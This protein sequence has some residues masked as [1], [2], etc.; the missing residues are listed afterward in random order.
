[1]C[2]TSSALGTR[3]P[4]LLGAT[5]ERIRKMSMASRSRRGNM[6]AMMPTG[7]SLRALGADK[8]VNILRGAYLFWYATES[9]DSPALVTLT[10]SSAGRR[11][12]PSLCGV[13]LG[14]CQ[15]VIRI[16]TTYCLR[17][18]QRF[19]N[20]ARG[21]VLDVCPSS[22]LSRPSIR[23]SRQARFHAAATNPSSAHLKT[24]TSA[25]TSDHTI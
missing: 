15:C 19:V 2:S 10:D 11:S 8:M 18:C 3:R 24:R 12:L 25:R 23:R 21:P 13:Y 16:C 17:T 6:K 7:L 5:P 14:P 20:E 9:F 4:A 22:M 1:M